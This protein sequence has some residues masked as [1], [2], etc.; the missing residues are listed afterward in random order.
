MQLQLGETIRKQYLSPANLCIHNRCT[1]YIKENV[2]TWHIKINLAWKQMPT[3]FSPKYYLNVPE[4]R[5]SQTLNRNNITNRD[6]SS[7]GLSTCAINWP[8]GLWH[9]QSFWASITQDWKCEGPDWSCL[10]YQSMTLVL[11]DCLR[12]PFFLPKHKQLLKTC[13]RKEALHAMLNLHWVLHHNVTVVWV[14]PSAKALLIR[15]ATASFV[16]LMSLWISSTLR[17]SS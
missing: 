10:V 7:F 11:L 3:M 12:F 1:W 17:G 13:K 8:H 6:I 16:I 15:A 4:L 14:S 5:W 2:S 9:S